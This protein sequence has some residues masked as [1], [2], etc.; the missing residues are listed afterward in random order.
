MGK[1][2]KNKA[3]ITLRDRSVHKSNPFIYNIIYI[4]I[5]FIFN[6][7]LNSSLFAAAEVQNV[8]VS[9]ATAAPGDTIT[10]T[11][12]MRSTT[13][14][15]ARFA[16]AY[17]EDT[18]LDNCDEDWLVGDEIYNRSGLT[19]VSYWVNGVTTT[20]TGIAYAG[21]GPR[22]GV[23]GNSTST[24]QTV[25][26][27]TAVPPEKS[28]NFRIFVLVRDNDALRYDCSSSTQPP[29]DTD[30]T[31]I[32]VS[33]ATTAYK[34]DLQ[35][36]SGGVTS[37][38]LKLYYRVYNWSE[39]AIR[40]NRV[41][42][43]YYM[44]GATQST[45]WSTAN[46]NW[47]FRQADGTSD[48]SNYTMSSEFVNTASSDCT[49]T[50]SYTRLSN[51]YLRMHW[52]NAN[53]IAIT[54]N[55][56]YLHT[57]QVMDVIN[58]GGFSTTDDYSRI[59]DSVTCYSQNKYLTVFYNHSSPTDESSDVHLCEYTSPSTVDSLSGEQPCDIS[60]CTRIEM[61]K[62]A[63]PMDATI[64]D[65][66]TYCIDFSNYSGAAR[67]FNIWDTVPA[68]M[69]LQGCNGCSVN[70]YGDTTV[71]WWPIN[72]LANGAAGQVCFWVTVARL[73]YFEIEKEFFASGVS[74]YLPYSTAVLN[75]A[76]VKSF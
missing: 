61:L 7:S 73:P 67:T 1:T 12:Q 10:V 66:I 15:T 59:E 56:G 19:S 4:L 17:S 30:Y 3:D 25:S 37:D 69:T 2:F 58:T 72:N 9:P 20:A 38:R 32:T 76:F 62:T 75:S 16:I 65:T 49:D 22:T 6:I 57:Q 45:G 23:T 18:T 31:D 63:N 26:I 47:Q 42:V 50:G 28:G 53:N 64:G 21:D 40:G 34:L 70:Y 33:G 44:N 71:V 24:F 14:Q 29:N 39:S 52:N 46:G 54:P 68:I 60:S 8:T 41:A 48:G 5:L 74:K 51:F 55:G 13:N 27:I 36:C 11:F 35:V 43:R